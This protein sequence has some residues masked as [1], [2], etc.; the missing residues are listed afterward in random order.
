MTTRRTRPVLGAV[1]LVVLALAAFALADP[2]HLR[3]APWYAGVLGTL[4]VVLV[5]L[6]ITLR[7]RRGLVRVLV[8][9]AGLLVA[10]V[11]VAFSWLSIS[12][13]PG[14]AVLREVPAPPGSRVRL[15]LV[16][17]ETLAADPVRY[18]VR[19][20]AGSGPFEQDAPV[21]VGLS[22]GA[23]PTTLRFGAPTAAGT[24]VEVVA[25]VDCGYRS[26]VDEVT[27][28]VDPVHSP[29]RLDGC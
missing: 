23:A 22:E 10:L 21:W 9:G 7:V 11:W 24:V 1:A 6:W 13:L 12:F 2:F 25:G 3:L 15:V 4:A 27:L 14:E 26:T 16:E 8:G 19:V 5:T 17:S 28:S 20:R 18:S 29:L